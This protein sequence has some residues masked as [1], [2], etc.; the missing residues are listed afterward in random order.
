MSSKLFVGNLSYTTGEAELRDAFVPY[1]TVT[2]V[3]IASDR[4]TG[5]PRGFAFVTFATD[6][7]ARAAIEKLNGTTI[8]G[9]VIAVN[10]ARPSGTTTTAEGRTFTSPNRKPGAF[11]QRGKRRH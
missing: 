4:F 10:E 7:E 8:D 3:H 1:G 5:R 11:Y 2:D 9:N 6:E